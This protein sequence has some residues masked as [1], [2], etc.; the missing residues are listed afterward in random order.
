MATTNEV[1]GPL[2][3]TLDIAATVSAII[4]PVVVVVILYLLREKIPALLKELAGRVTK[5]DIAGVTLEF[6]KAKAFEPEFASATAG[7]KG[8]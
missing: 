2:K 8:R 4:W 3:V 7:Q 5:L 6:A 1:T